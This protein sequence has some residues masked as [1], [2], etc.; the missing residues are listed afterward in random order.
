MGTQRRHVLSTPATAGSA[1][2]KDLG[3][4]LAFRLA[5][6]L[7][8]SSVTRVWLELLY[9]GKPRSQPVLARVKDYQR[10]RAG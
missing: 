4:L 5:S 9:P 10:G 8:V 7:L 2:F 3:Q 6:S 1:P